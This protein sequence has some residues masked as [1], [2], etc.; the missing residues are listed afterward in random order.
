MSAGPSLPK[1]ILDHS[2][3]LHV[4]LT[5]HY[6]EVVC[7]IQRLVSASDAYIRPN[8]LDT[9]FDFIWTATAAAELVPVCLQEDMR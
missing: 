7:L 3:A 9:N 1:V 5:N 8:R 4:W 6:I 2:S